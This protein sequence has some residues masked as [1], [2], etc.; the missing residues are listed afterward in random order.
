MV[1]KF[2]NII[3]DPQYTITLHLTEEMVEFV[4]SGDTITFRKFEKYEII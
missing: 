3:A 2:T 4:D 1:D